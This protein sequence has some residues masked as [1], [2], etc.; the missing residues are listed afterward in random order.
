MLETIRR[1]RRLNGG[2]WL[3]F[4]LWVML[5]YYFGRWALRRRFA[6]CRWLLGKLYGLNKFVLLCVTH[7][8]VHREAD[9]GRDL[10]LVHGSNIHVHPGVKIGDECGIMHD[11]TLGTV[12]QR[13]GVPVIGDKVFIGA[14][15]KV[16]GPVRI[17]DGAVVGANS[18]VLQDVPD[19]A[20][21]V[22]VP[23]RIIR[24]TGRTGPLP[25]HDDREE[26]G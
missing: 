19:G 24:Y 14:G 7:S 9:I 25:R 15:A 26:V 21:A 11:V 3:S 5:N 2:S 13:Q 22:G 23:A 6:L 16:L 17:G 20:M 12:P 4:S 1:T 8:E 18:L 10:H